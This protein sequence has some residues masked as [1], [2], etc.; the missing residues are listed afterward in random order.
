MGLG[1]VPQI[2]VVSNALRK[3]NG[4]VSIPSVALKDKEKAYNFTNSLSRGSSHMT[5]LPV[6]EKFINWHDLLYLE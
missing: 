3:R 2:L 5:Q 6:H 4:Q 1:E